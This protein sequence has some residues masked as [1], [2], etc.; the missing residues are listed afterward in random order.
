MGCE[1]IDIHARLA[2]GYEDVMS[3]RLAGWICDGCGAEASA[4]SHEQWLDN[5]VSGKFT[6]I[7]RRASI[8]GSRHFCPECVG[9]IPIKKKEK[10]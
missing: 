9:K 5:W 8:S 1:A 7:T 6:R 10:A 4:S 3:L 2:R